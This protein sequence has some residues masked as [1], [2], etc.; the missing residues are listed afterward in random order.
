MID[1]EKKNGR[2]RPKTLIREHIVEL[3]MIKYWQDGPASISLNQICHDTHVSKPGIYREF[4]GEDGLKK[5]VLEHYKDQVI[6]KQFELLKEVRPFLDTLEALMDWMT[7][8]GPFPSGCLYVK[9]RSSQNSLGASTN[10]L[11]ESIR[12]EMQLAY[13]SWF[14]RGLSQDEVNPAIDSHLAAYYIETQLN[15]AL[16]LVEAG[17]PIETIRSTLRLAFTSLLKK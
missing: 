11:V 5:A 12:K 2:G 14:E 6:Q 17:E 8:K 15:N 9:M 16:N 1:K 7:T 13:Q 10:Q 4:G 3:A